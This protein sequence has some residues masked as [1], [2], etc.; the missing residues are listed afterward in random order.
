MQSSG[1]GD[2]E[3]SV[4]LDTSGLKKDTEKIKK[5]IEQGVKTG[6]TDIY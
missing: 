3:L 6:N 4:T 2:V 5:E 1:K